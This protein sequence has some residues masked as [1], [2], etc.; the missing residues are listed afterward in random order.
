MSVRRNPKHLQE[1]DKN[2][3]RSKIRYFCFLFVTSYS[4]FTSWHFTFKHLQAN[5][6]IISDTKVLTLTF[7]FMFYHKDEN[8]CF[9]PAQ[10]INFSRA[11]NWLSTYRSFSSSLGEVKELPEL[12]W[13]PAFVISGTGFAASWRDGCSGWETSL[14]RATLFFNIEGILGRGRGSTVATGVSL[15]SCFF[16]NLDFSCSSST[17]K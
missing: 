14:P 16:S 17:Q 12:A 13:D 6:T 5:Y 15:C 3:N 9:N 11:D 4:M 8:Y 7:L 10:Y 1:V 2:C